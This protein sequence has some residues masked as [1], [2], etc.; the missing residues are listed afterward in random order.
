MPAP[1]AL[2]ASPLESMPGPSA[3]PVARSDGPGESAPQV[4]R[5]NAPRTRLQARIRKPKIYSNWNHL[6]WEF[7]NF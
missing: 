7:Y 6:L 5:Q 3:C 2:G 1:G 4:G